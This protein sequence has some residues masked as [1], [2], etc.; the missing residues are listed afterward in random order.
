LQELLQVGLDPGVGFYV[1]PIALR[2]MYL[3]VAAFYQPHLRVLHG[4][5]SIGAIVFQ[6]EVDFKHS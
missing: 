3:V 5:T 1:C 6:P 2:H 4:K